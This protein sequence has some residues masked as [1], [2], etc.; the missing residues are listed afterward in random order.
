MIHALFYFRADLAILCLMQN[1]PAQQF[2][3]T[4]I[5]PTPS[6]FLHIGNALSFALTAA[7][8]RTS[9]AKIL[10]RIDDLDQQ[11]VNDA[12]VQDIFDTLNFLE[13]NWDEGPRDLADYKNNWSQLHRMDLYKDALLQLEDQREVFACKCSRSQLK[14]GNYPGTCRNRS[15]PL[16]TPET[17]WR[18]YTN[19]RELDI[20]TL[21]QGIIKTQLPAGM[22]DFV[23]KK[24]DDHSAYQ[25]AS[26]IDDLHFGVD[27]VVRGEDLYPSTIAQYYLA[28]VLG[29][30]DFQNITFHHHQLLMEYGDK[31]LSKSAGST[32]IKYLR[33]QGTTAA[34]VYGE[35]GKMLGAGK[36]LR[37]F[38]NFVSLI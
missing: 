17:A 7:L 21:N 28:N 22:N 36:D 19:E 9:G 2:N 3:K 13:I 23:V 15:L 20:K 26:L 33:E 4:R 37:G 11:R 24:K 32:S 10:L 6:G 5:A 38:E 34:D 35:I 29:K 12:Y 30:D 18:L 1:N 14:D 27:L 25:L 16:D 8:A 31:K